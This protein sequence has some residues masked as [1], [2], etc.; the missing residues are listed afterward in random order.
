MTVLFALLVLSQVADLYLTQR[1]LSLGAKE[2][3]PVSRWI[4]ERTGSVWLGGLAV[5][6][7][8]LVL[9]YLA[10]EPVLVAFALALYGWVVWNNWS[11]VKRLGG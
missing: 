3:N 9:V 6:V 4:I 5:K 10:G 2:A 8:V 11:V 7:P 1:A